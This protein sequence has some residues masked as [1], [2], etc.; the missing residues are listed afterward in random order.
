MSDSSPG[1]TRWQMYR[2]RLLCGSC[3]WVET[4]RCVAMCARCSECGR[5]Y[6]RRWRSRM[7]AEGRCV[8]CGSVSE[9][10]RCA[11][12]KSRERLRYRRIAGKR[13]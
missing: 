5:E 7:R 4:G 8:D 1:V 2:S 6:S 10:R 11:A 3:G 9:P 13:R 12:R